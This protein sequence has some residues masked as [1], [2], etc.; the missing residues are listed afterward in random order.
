MASLLPFDTTL[1]VRVRQK[2]ITF[3]AESGGNESLCDFS[4][5]KP[6]TAE[7]VY[8]EARNFNELG[9]GNINPY[10]K[11]EL[12]QQAPHQHFRRKKK[13]LHPPNRPSQRDRENPDPV[14]VIKVNTTTLTTIKT[15]TT[16][17]IGA[18]TNK[19]STT[20]GATETAIDQEGMEER[21][22]Q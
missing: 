19:T 12:H 8:A 3:R 10:A 17:I 2:A 9:F 15:E 7:E 18:A 4:A 14:E 22:K 6:Q 1:H 5:F 21:R 16:T 11:G 13:N 20:K